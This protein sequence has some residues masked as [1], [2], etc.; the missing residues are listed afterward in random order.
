MSE[1]LNLW[2]VWT[3]AA[4]ALAVIEV[5]VP[6][7]IFLGFAIGALAMVGI[8][9]ATPGLSAPALLAIFGGLS[10][11]AWIGLRMAFRKQSSGAK[12]VHQD[13]NDN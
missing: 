4:L 10:L 5:L 9:F 2:W 8:I 6:G 13:I 12:I 7:F 1:L 3:A 11:V